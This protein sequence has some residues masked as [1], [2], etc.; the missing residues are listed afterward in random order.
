[1]NKIQELALAMINYDNGDPKRIQHFMKVHAF[2][3]LIGEMENIDK[4]ILF[5]LET[6]AVVHDIG[7]KSAEEKSSAL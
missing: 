2:S 3:K 7:I 6:A 5:T 1:M 4:N